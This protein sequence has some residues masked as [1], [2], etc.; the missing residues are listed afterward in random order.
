MSSI[1]PAVCQ[2]TSELQEIAM[3]GEG[4]R[5]GKGE[6]RAWVSWGEIVLPSEFSGAW[7]M[8]MLI[9]IFTPSARPGPSSPAAVTLFLW[10]HDNSSP[11]ASWI[12]EYV[13]RGKVSANAKNPQQATTGKH[14]IASD[15]LGRLLPA[16]GFSNR[17]K[18]YLSCSLVFGPRQRQ[19]SVKVSCTD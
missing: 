5:V 10:I 18:L 7:R 1:S 11:C 14:L 13:R 9:F 4:D 6:G 19:R 12:A 2:H 16:P 8:N 17:Y 3:S 15:C